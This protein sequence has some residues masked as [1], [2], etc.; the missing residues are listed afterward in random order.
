MLC[1][2][3]CWWLLTEAG[4]TGLGCCALRF[5]DTLYSSTVFVLGLQGCKN[6]QCLDQLHC[7]FSQNS[8]IILVSDGSGEKRRY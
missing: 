3:C 4:S 8:Y 5:F 2:G 7:F 6:K 1:G